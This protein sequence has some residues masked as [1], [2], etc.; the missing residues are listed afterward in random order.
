MIYMCCSSRCLAIN[1]SLTG[2]FLKSLG[3]YTFRESISSSRASTR[4][5]FNS[6]IM[7]QPLPNPD[8]EGVGG[9]NGEII[10]GLGSGGKLEGLDMA[11]V[12]VCRVNSRANP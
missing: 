1:T 2:V 3:S 6:A 11:V 12:A 4:S 8:E 10:H 5:R 7:N 9:G